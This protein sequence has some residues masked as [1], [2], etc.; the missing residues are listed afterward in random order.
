ME[1]HLGVELSHVRVHSDKG[2]AQ[3]S[4]RI[5]ARAFTYQ[6]D[7][8]LGAGESPSDIELMAH[9]VTHVAQQGAAQQKGVQRQVSVGAADHPAEKQADQVAAQAV[10]QRKPKPTE[11]ILESAENGLE[12][13]QVL[14]SRFMAEL[15]QRVTQTANAELGPEWS[16]LG[17]PYIEQFFARNRGKSARQLERMIRRYSGVRRPHRASDYVGPIL[18]RLRAGVAKWR[19][20]GDISSDLAA[21]GMGHL[22][23]KVS[24]AAEASRHEDRLTQP[25]NEQVQRKPIPMAPPLDPGRP[26]RIA[27]QLGDGAPIDPGAASSIGNAMG[28]SFADV[29]VHTG[30]K[31]Q[32]MAEKLDAR[33]FTVGNQVGFNAGEYRPNTPEGDAVLAHELAHV[34]QQRG[35]DPKSARELPVGEAGSAHENDADQAAAGVVA[36]LHGGA[37]RVKSNAGVALRSGFTL[38]RCFGKSKPKMAYDGRQYARR[39]QKEIYKEV[40]KLL[41]TGVTFGTQSK[42]ATW[43]IGSSNDFAAQVIASMK[44]GG[45]FLGA[46]ESAIAPR[47]LQLVTD[48]GREMSPRSRAQTQN[49]LP[50]YG[51]GGWTPTV[52]I[53]L[54][55]A[56]VLSIRR[57]LKRI[58]P[59]YVE[60]TSRASKAKQAKPDLSP[61]EI[62]HAVDLHVLAALRRKT[63]QVDVEAYAKDH[64]DARPA[65]DSN[66]RR[67]IVVTQVKENWWRATSFDGQQVTASDFA[68]YQLGSRDQ[69][70]RVIA[71][72][73]LFGLKSE[74]GESYSVAQQML[75]SKEGQEAALGQA[76][77]FAKAPQCA[78]KKAVVQTIL[79]NKRWMV[80]IEQR[81]GAFGL[82]FLLGDAILRLGRLAQ[83]LMDGDGD[84][85]SK[86][87]SQA[88]LQ[89][90]IL[91]NANTGLL[92]TIEELKRAARS[93]KQI[94]SGS[95]ALAVPEH[96]RDILV[97]T[98]TAFVRAAAVSDL[99]GTAGALLG[100]A[101][102]DL[103][104]YRIRVVEHLLSRIAHVAEKAKKKTDTSGMR[105]REAQLR[106]RLAQFR[107]DLLNNAPGVY[108]R[109][110]KFEKELA[111]LQEETSIVS[112]VVALGDACTLLE[113][114]GKETWEGTYKEVQATIAQ[115]RSYQK[116]I[117]SIHADWRKGD[118]AKARRR[119][120]SLHK[121]RRFQQFFG[122][123]KIALEQAGQQ[124]AYA[125]T[126][127]TLIVLG[128]TMGVG[129]FFTGI[130]EGA[131]WST[132]KTMTVTSATMAL[133]TA[134]LNQAFF[135]KRR[136]LMKFVSDAVTNFAT[137]GALQYVA[138]LE[139]LVGEGM[140]GKALTASAQG[141]AAS[142]L[143]LA[144]KQIEN[145]LEHKGSITE[146]EA[147]QIVG[148]TVAST[149]A[150][151]VLERGLKPILEKLESRG[152]ALGKA[153]AEAN[154]L[155]RALRQQALEVQQSRSPEQARQLL[156]QN[157]ASIEAD[158]RVVETFEK[159]DSRSLAKQGVSKSQE[160]SGLRRQTRQAPGGDLDV[161]ELTGTAK[162]LP[163]VDGLQC[164][165][166]PHGAIE[167][168]RTRL[169]ERGETL[170]SYSPEPVTNLP[171][172]IVENKI[173]REAAP[174][175]PEGAPPSPG[176]DQLMLGGRTTEQLALPSRTRYGRF[177]G[178]PPN[179]WSRLGHYFEPSARSTVKSL[180]ETLARES[181]EYAP[182]ADEMT[183]YQKA[184]M[185][186]KQQEYFRRIELQA[187][188]EIWRIE[189]DL[190]KASGPERAQLETR[191]ARARTLLAAAKVQPVAGILPQN[192]EF[193]GRYYTVE[194][195][196]NALKSSDAAAQTKQAIQAT[197]ELLLKAG[198]KGIR[199]TN[200]GYPDFL[201][202]AYEVGGKTGDVR[203]K[204]TGSRGKDFTAADEAMRNK[205]KDPSWKRPKDYT[206]HHHQQLGRMILVKT[207]VHMA[208]KHTG[209]VAHY[210]VLSARFDAYPRSD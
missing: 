84:E 115:G 35:A 188:S 195:L 4:Q 20:G 30:P 36:R 54:G 144:Q 108:K 89:E 40:R 52:G 143:T 153:L 68:L 165:E 161:I 25:P 8:F 48:Q 184:A 122:R 118:K 23:P 97:S 38:Q 57:S 59:A 113:K 16:A 139:A 107:I 14:K 119:L 37:Q 145:W 130:A 2:A 28:E 7:I 18:A 70:H 199:F 197:I 66:V 92:L 72:P 192:H 99:V 123:V 142:V 120:D 80:Q 157:R 170:K 198:K 174:E 6:S 181:R 51:P 186:R 10:K 178:N 162:P 96:V 58:M 29:K 132:L 1:G 102:E 60:E 43:V 209:G 15:R 190:A 155:R 106:A 34:A 171:R 116:L 39:H 205:I 148:Q 204:L 136:G 24:E 33:A 154:A 185:F 17:C 131:G 176:V 133:T 86:W 32:R 55:N 158:K 78:S 160:L 156:E 65:R 90:T 11:F 125:N 193:A 147:A 151:K 163:N 168:L 183:G 173:F 114:A 31:A 67:A 76:G 103:R 13:G 191:L 73:P 62:C 100:R 88:R 53:D 98:A 140:L 93:K 126:I 179:P 42:Y 167:T 19:A 3:A 208:I 175:G 169:S 194:D 50:G 74:S 71:A 149:I 129:K 128:A 79:D 95:L 5:G 21:V 152:D 109:L 27:D 61:I 202:F 64:P 159:T 206:W 75:S 22:A 101:H 87:Y 110:A 83:R 56:L 85:A 166:V 177:V 127:K 146:E 112:Y 117:A 141:G 45:D 82:G 164:F 172:Y 41:A 180:R 189:R 203:I 63:V 121:D 138:K 46:L 9:E 94:A 69:A 12:P 137:F 77:L 44:Q 105:K 91:R 26:A 104:L 81:A 135:K 111:D 134:G 207:D 200:D 201:E 182:V 124:A 196:R 49:R 187:E 47:S 210:R 150:G